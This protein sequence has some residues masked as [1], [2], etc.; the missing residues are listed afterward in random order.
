[1][2][3]SSFKVTAWLAITG[4]LPV[5]QRPTRDADGHVRTVQLTLADPDLSPKGVRLK[6]LPVLERPI[7]KLVFLM[8]AARWK[9]KN[10]GVSPPRSHEHCILS[11]SWWFSRFTKNYEIEQFQ[12]SHV[13]A[14]ERSIV[15]LIW[16]PRFRFPFLTWLQLSLSFDLFY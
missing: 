4:N 5:S 9:N 2:T 15:V 7:H 10:R 6:P 12:G 13:T 8:Q 16:S 1:M 11:S 14:A 3:L